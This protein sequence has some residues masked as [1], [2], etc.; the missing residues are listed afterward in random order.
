MTLGS[1]ILI[2]DWIYDCQYFLWYNQIYYKKKNKIFAFEALYINMHYKKET[3]ILRTYIHIQ[4]VYKN[5]FFSNNS[6]VYIIDYTIIFI[7]YFT[8]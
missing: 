7:I 3:K 8:L 4:V 5:I 1:I 2:I 6:R